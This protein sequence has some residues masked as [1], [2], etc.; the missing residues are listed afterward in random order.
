MQRCG[1]RVALWGVVC[2][3]GLAAT[4]AWAQT[5]TP[6]T[7][8]KGKP[9]RLRIAVDPWAGTPISTAE[10]EIDD[11]TSANHGRP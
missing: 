9:E 4:V 2:A 5:A 3:I 1:Y 7:P 11:E 8:A 10:E 6:P